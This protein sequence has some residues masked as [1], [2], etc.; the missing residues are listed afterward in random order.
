MTNPTPAPSSSLAVLSVV[1]A[2][3]FP[4][5]GIALGA[6]ALDEIR[7][8]GERGRAAA[9]VGIVLGIV[10]TAAWTVIVVGYLAAFT[11]I[12]ALSLGVVP[13]Y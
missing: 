10:F 4:P 8:T 13:W 1:F 2:V 5:L 3:L 11:F 7:T 9:K 6:L 12:A